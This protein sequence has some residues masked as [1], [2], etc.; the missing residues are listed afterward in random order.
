[1]TCSIVSMHLMDGLK[2]VSSDIAHDLRT[3][4]SRLKQRLEEARSEANSVEEYKEAVDQA[5]QDADIALSTFGAL[6]RIA[7]I[8][9]GTRRANFSDL[10]LFG[11]WQT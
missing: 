8:E 11:S 9:S 4:L 7:Q 2:Q 5:I 10:D 3:P 6:L 1:M